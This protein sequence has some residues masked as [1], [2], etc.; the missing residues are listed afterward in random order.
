VGRAAGAGD[1][2]LIPIVAVCAS[3]ESLHR[4]TP[5]GAR[6]S[7]S[8]SRAATTSPPTTSTARALELRAARWVSVYG[9]PRHVFEPEALEEW[10]EER[11]VLVRSIEDA[12]LASPPSTA[13]WTS[14][15]RARCRS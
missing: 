1:E 12:A 14:A 9:L 7:R 4:M 8:S 11:G 6:I 13:A 10:A 15:P 2:H 3:I 5:A